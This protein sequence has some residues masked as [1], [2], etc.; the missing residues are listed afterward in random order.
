MHAHGL[1]AARPQSRVLT[2]GALALALAAAMPPAM[3]QTL[4][5]VVVTATRREASLQDIGV[6][7]TAFTDAEM[8]Q[9]N[10]VR[11][12]DIANMTPG[13]QYVVGSATPL[14]GLISIRGVAQNDFSSHLEG[15]N[16]LYVD[17]VYRPSIG[18]YIQNFFDV[19]RAEVLKGPQG[20]LFGRNATGGLIHMITREPGD[21]LNGYLQGTLGEYDQI[22]VEGAVGGPLGAGI[23]G[24]V[25]FQHAEHDGW[26]E[27][28]IGP[29]SIED[30]TTAVRGKL[31]MEPN[32]RLRIKLQAEWFQTRP[33]DGGGGFATGGFVG[34]DTLGR[35]KAPPAPTDAG[36]VDADGSPFT[37]E[38]D[39]PGKYERDEYMI[40]ADLQ[41]THE[42]LLFTSITAYSRLDDDYTEDNDLTPI[43]LTIFRTRSEQKNFSQELRLNADFDRQR[44]T[45]G[46]Y[47]LNIDGTYFQNF[48]INNLGAGG[49]SQIATGAPP[50][51]IPLGFNQFAN[52]SVDTESWS[53]Y[54]QGEMDLT[55]ALT[56]TGGLRYTE[57]SKDYRYLNTCQNLL[58]FPACP[59][60]FDPATLA[61]AGR[62]SDDHTEDGV[63][64]RVQLDYRIGDDWLVFASYNRGYKAF[65]YNAGFAGAAAV[66]NARF[67]GETLNAFEIGTKSDFWGGRA[68][69]NASAFYYLYEDYQAFDQ[70]GTDFILSNT[71][72]N[73]YGAD[74]ELT[75]SPGYG[76]NFLFGLALL[77][78][79][80]D[81]IPIGGQLLEREAPQSPALTFNF[82]AA[83]DFQIGPG[84]VR[85]ALDGLYID[86][87]FSQL[88]NAPVTRV[89]DHW[90]LNGR[91]SF[92]SSDERWEA[93]VFVRNM[94]DEERLLYAFDITFPGNGLVEQTFAPPRWVGG[95]VRFNF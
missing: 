53:I 65:S 57:D 77:E 84:T 5:E 42:N 72:A 47:Y 18:S 64:A 35:F 63:S 61:G 68:R 19:E 93:S 10:I 13:L 70:R 25:A 6:S 31:L 90:L 94:L 81:D 1:I 54:A 20:T 40:F 91:L 29:D 15:A 43:D 21:E 23:S 14:V 48:Q 74:A 38:F 37:G 45:A 59:P 24:R 12:D 71:D 56:I 50:F 85:V 26:I 87:Y 8:R 69:L 28:A 17:D 22:I 16:V 73:V 3:A 30:D 33:V 79:E 39:F 44:L 80:V 67:K 49:A 58:P 2:A 51:L 88:T 55:P 9:F 82:A 92:F 7:V 4:E 76:L 36:Y 32:E 83:K 75:V 60:A 52:F 89:G 78:T 34:P 62:V 11:S 66:D 27:N 95:Q 86:D 46:F 41:Y